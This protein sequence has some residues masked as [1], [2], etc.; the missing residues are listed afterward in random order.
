MIIILLSKSDKLNKKYRVLIGD[1]TIY[2]GDAAYQDYTQHNDL[3]RKDLYLT[4]HSKREDFNNPLT[5]GFWS[6]WLLWN[7]KTIS[8]SIKDIKKRFNL[9]IINLVI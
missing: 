8:K 1:K 5:A 4:R 9:K 2:F 6:R 7:K 3:H